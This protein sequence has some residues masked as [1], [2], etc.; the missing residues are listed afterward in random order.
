MAAIL[1]VIGRLIGAGIAKDL[2]EGAE[3]D[4]EEQTVPVSSS[5]IR[6][7]GYRSDGV[8]TVDFIRG[9]T[10]SYEGSKE[11]FLAFLA[12]PSKGQFFNSHFQAG[13]R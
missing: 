6:A 8:I 7:I 5:C 4:L 12:A 2:L 9:G 13:G 10:Y 1:G 11:L 3:E